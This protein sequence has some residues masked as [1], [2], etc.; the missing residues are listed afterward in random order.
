MADF[1][2][3]QSMAFNPAQPFL[4]QTSGV[5]VVTV[6]AT[7]AERTQHAT[8]FVNNMEV[9]KASSVD[10]AGPL[11]VPPGNSPGPQSASVP[12][13]R[14]ARWTVMMAEP[15]TPQSKVFWVPLQ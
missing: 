11:P 4:A 15:A 3:Y 2:A 10:F 5:V 12:V 6:V 8:I 1:L 13:P 9:A 7:P 14:G